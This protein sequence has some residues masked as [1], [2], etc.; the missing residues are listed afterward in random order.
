MLSPQRRGQEDVKINEMIE[1]CVN[2]QEMWDILQ[3]SLDALSQ[4]VELDGGFILPALV[5]PSTSYEDFAKSWKQFPV[6]L[7]RV[8]NALVHARETRQST[9]IMP[10]TA[11]HMSDCPHGFYHCLKRRR[12][13]CST[14][15]CDEVGHY[16]RRRHGRGD[17]HGAPANRLS[18]GT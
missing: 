13:S 10:T 6:A 9:T 8:R 12:G 15:D 5:I 14:V 7:H 11:N 16:G 4:D 17:R 18:P 1:E 2:T 3:G